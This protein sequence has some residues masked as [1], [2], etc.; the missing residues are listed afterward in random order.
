MAAI[1]IYSINVIIV[2]KQASVFIMKTHERIRRLV[3]PHNLH[4]NAKA[5]SFMCSSTLRP[6][7]PTALV[8]PEC[9][10]AHLQLLRKLCEFKS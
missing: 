5:S 6:S 3:I 1:T 4:T 2:T 8:D 7:R 10:C 9:I